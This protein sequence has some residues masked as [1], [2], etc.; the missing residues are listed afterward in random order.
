MQDELVAT[1]NACILCWFSCT[2]VGM[3]DCDMAL[4]AHPQAALFP[5]VTW[6]RPCASP[7]PVMS[8]SQRCKRG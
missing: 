5:R 1:L 7:R 8:C 6:R 2:S 3:V 4:T